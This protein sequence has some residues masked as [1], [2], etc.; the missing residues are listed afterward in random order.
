[1][2]LFQME[3][4]AIRRLRLANMTERVLHRLGDSAQQIWT[5]D[6]IKSYIL[7]GARTLAQEKVMWDQVYLENLPAGFSHTGEFEEEYMTFSYGRANYTAE[8]EAEYIDPDFVEVDLSRRANHTSPGDLPY[9]V[10]IGASTL[11]D[12]TVQ[13]PETLVEIE[14]AVN[15]NRVI[16]A[17]RVQRIQPRDSRYEITQ[18]EVFAFTWEKDGPYTLR[19]IRVPNEMPD[20][21]EYNGSWGLIRNADDLETGES[22]SGSFGV[23]R[24]VAGHHPIGNTEGW[25]IPRRFYQDGKNF[26]VDHWRQFA[27]EDDTTGSELPDRYFKYLTDYAQ[28]RA[29]IRNGAGQNY[30]LAELYKTKW[31]RGVARVKRRLARKDK[32]RAGILG[33]T[34]GMRARREPPTPKLPWQYGSQ[35]R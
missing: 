2:F 28:W 17:T 25:G 21:Y 22:V 34:A 20:I 33:G 6:E 9:L 10:D 1:M 26:R 24:I 12:A 18:G 8:F 7:R 5:F 15:D 32:E 11:G 13:V 3:G 30:Q 29:L 19:K 14:R 4:D 27:T 31:D 23:L 35:I 16:D